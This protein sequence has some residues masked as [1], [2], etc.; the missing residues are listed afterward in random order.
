VSTRTLKKRIKLSTGNDEIIPVP[1]LISLQKDSFKIFLNQAI[2]SELLAISPIQGYGGRFEMEFMEDIKVGEPEHTVEECRLR[3]TS[4]AFPLRVNC[5]LIDKE[6]GEVKVQ[7]V[8][9]GEIPMMT[10]AGTFLINGAE[11]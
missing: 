7:E 3:E 2:R 10:D 11:R 8:F 4:Y 5:R 9:M 1:N 6:T